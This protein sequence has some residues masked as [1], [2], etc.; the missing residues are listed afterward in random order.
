MNRTKDPLHFHR[1]SIDRS[2]K[3]DRPDRVKAS[4]KVDNDKHRF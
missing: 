1:S 4:T 2:Q 3:T